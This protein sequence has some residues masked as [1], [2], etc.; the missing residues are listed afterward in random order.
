MANLCLK[1]SNEDRVGLVFD[2]SRILAKQNMNIVSME[3]VPGITYLEIELSHP[4]E[5]AM[6][7]AKLSA[8]PQVNH[9]V[10]IFQMPYQEREQELKTVMDTIGDGIMAINRQEVVIHF[11]AAAEKMLSLKSEKVIGRKLSDIFTA[12]PPLLEILHS[13]RPYSNREVML[14]TAKGRNHYLISGCPIADNHGGVAG[15]VAVL[16][17]MKDVEELVYTVTNPEIN[18]FNQILHV[19]KVMEHTIAVAKRVAQN[20]STV[21]IRGESGTGKELFARSIHTASPRQDRIF[22]PINCAAMPDALL[23]SELFGYEEGAFTGAK[24]YGKTG[25]FEYANG[26]TVFLD[27]IGDLSFNLQA[28]LL[29]VLQEGTIKRLGGNR[30]ISVDVRIIAATHS[31][32]E[33]MLQKNQFREDLYYRLNVIPL[34][35]PP[36]RDRKEDLPLLIESLLFKKNHKFKKHVKHILKPAMEK[37]IE[38]DWPG[39]V[40]ELENVLERAVNFSSQGEITPDDIILDHAARA[41]A[42]SDF[43]TGKSR[44]LKEILEETEC[45]ILYEAVNK[46]RSS[47]QVGKILGLS[48]TGV[49][50]RMKK[51]N[52]PIRE[53]NP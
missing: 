22:A 49:L 34:F 10:R 39:N 31:N 3:V 51:Y 19:S 45:S 41:T 29:R 8:I 48:H 15:A 21:L 47:R 30:E 35:I 12:G 6:L 38:Y 16:K 14:A 37:L 46:Y 23:E 52:I 1:I 9:V 28:K 25:L 43:K 20:D 53:P 7:E 2:I 17:S 5:E 42:K 32:L 44:K 18:S 36:L 24:K 40:R 33:Q 4:R 27:E 50:N 13:G 26:G 11:N